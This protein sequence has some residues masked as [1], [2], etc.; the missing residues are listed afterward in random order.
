[1]KLMKVMK[2]IGTK[3][4]MIPCFK[5]ADASN[6][7]PAAAWD[8]YS[9]WIIMMNLNPGSSQASPSH[10]DGPGRPTRSLESRTVICTEYRFK[11]VHAY[12]PAVCT[13]PV[14]SRAA[15]S[16]DHDGIR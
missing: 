12:T 1:M 8:D 14:L 2:I 15:D 5:F 7:S 6:N 13:M 10:L 9:S 4:R 16:D 11:F 3:K